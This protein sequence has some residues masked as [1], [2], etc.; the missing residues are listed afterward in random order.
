MSFWLTSFKSSSCSCFFSLI[1]ILPHTLKSSETKWWSHVR[2]EVQVVWKW[3]INVDIFSRIFFY[4]KFNKSVLKVRLQKQFEIT[5]NSLQ[6]PHP[7]PTNDS[8]LSDLESWNFRW[9]DSR[10]SMMLKNLVPLNCCRQIKQTSRLRSPSREKKIILTSHKPPLWHVMTPI[11]TIISKT[12]MYLECLIRPIR[13]LTRPRDI[14]P[15]DH[16]KTN[17]AKPNLQL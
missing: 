3:I 10:W 4:V 1:A 6:C 5:W 8:R 12:M 11:Q 13:N 2:T 7:K 9:A 15:C 17:F 16:S 14:L